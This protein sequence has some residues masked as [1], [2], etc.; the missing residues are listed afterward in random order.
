M[1]RIE[2]IEMCPKFLLFLKEKKLYIVY[3]ISTGFLFIFSRI[4]IVRNRYL[5][6]PDGII[7]RYYKIGKL[8]SKKRVTYTT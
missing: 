3:Q 1:G 8:E 4:V 2:R 7:K 6:L 5:L